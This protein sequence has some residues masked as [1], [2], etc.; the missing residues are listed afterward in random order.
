MT[1]E[2]EQNE[3]EKRER[4]SFRYLWDFIFFN[5]IFVA[6]DFWKARKEIRQV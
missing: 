2:R 3:G 1:M 4:E 6:L 5:L